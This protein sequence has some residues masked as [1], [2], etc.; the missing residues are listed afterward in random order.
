MVMKADNENLRSGIEEV[1]RQMRLDWQI[2]AYFQQPRLSG[3]DSDLDMSSRSKAEGPV[4]LLALD[5]GFP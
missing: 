1:R 5:C 2:A 4:L 3:R